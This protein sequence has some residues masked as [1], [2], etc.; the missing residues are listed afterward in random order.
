M[1]QELECRCWGAL[2]P[3]PPFRCHVTRPH[4]CSTPRGLTLKIAGRGKDC[5][6]EVF[7]HSDSSA[8]HTRAYSH[9]H[10]VRRTHCMAS[11][12]CRRQAL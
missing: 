9:H 4:G 8:G 6:K 10:L 1:F 5:Y 7:R 3:L 11:S 2:L 12:G